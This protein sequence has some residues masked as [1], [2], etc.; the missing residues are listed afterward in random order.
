MNALVTKNFGSA[1]AA[2]AYAQAL[3][4]SSEKNKGSDGLPILKLG[5]DD[6]LWYFGEDNT[7]VAED[8]L[9]LVDC[10]NIM[11]G[12]VAFKLG[13]NGLVEYEDENGEEKQAEFLISITEDEDDLYDTLPELEPE[14]Y[15]KDRKK[16]TETPE[17]K[18]T[19]VVRLRC[20]EGE[21]EGEV[22]IYKPTAPS[23]ISEV[24]KM[25]SE[26]SK[27]ILSEDES[28]FMPI[29]ELTS[30]GF[31][32]KNYGFIRTPKF[33]YVD[34]VFPNDESF[35]SDRDDEDTDEE[36]KPKTKKTTTKKAPPKKTRKKKEPEPE[37]DDEDEYEEEVEEDVVD[38]E[39][40]E[41]EEVEEDEYEEEVVEEKP[42][43]RTARKPR[44]TRKPKKREDVPEDDAPKRTRKK[45]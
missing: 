18:Y 29:I 9:W 20:I 33:G 30:G 8:D 13:E 25:E 16:V 36:E 44:T 10:C 23:A 11:H 27:R 6:G 38:L 40:D 1:A 5:K 22:A 7:A 26:V 37:L 17:Y 43:T 42:K 31:K 32:S 3:K 35:V 28:P 41:Y 34:W 2:K 19:K 21:N 4:K 14:T 12:F 24:A 39:V 45:R 15:K